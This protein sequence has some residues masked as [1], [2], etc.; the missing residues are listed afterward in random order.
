MKFSK[1]LFFCVLSVLFCTALSAREVNR[2]ELESAGSQ[3]V[4]QFENYT[5]PHSVIDSAAAI[6]GIGIS[7][8]T[9]VSYKPNEAGTFYAS[10][11][12]YYVIHAVDESEK[13]KL[14]A[15]IFII[16]K[17]ATV[18]HIRNLRWIIGSYLQKAYG[19]SESDASTI[20]TFITVYN[21]VYRGKLDVFK[22]KY[23]DVV[24]KNLSADK[25]G[26]STKYSEWPGAT[27]IVIPLND[28]DGGL[29]TI[30]TSVISDKKVVE[31]MQEEDDKGIDERKN[32]VDIKE[33]E[34]EEANENAQ[35]AQKKATEEKAKAKEEQKKADEAKAEAAKDPDN[36][37]KQQA[38][39]EAQKKADEQKQ[40]AEESSE[41][42]SEKQAFADKKQTEAQSERKEIAKDQEKVAEAEMAEA[43]ATD[44][45]IGLKVTDS[46][47]GLS[48]MVKVDGATGKTLRESPV[49]VIRGRTI[50]S[51]TSED[52]ESNEAGSNSL[53][54][55]ICGENTG[56]GAIKLCVLD[57]NK[58]EIQKESN[59]AVAENS[60]L[61]RSGSDILCVI[62]SDGK[63]YLAKYDANLKLIFTSKECVSADTPITVTNKGIVVTAE[64][65]K[66]LLLSKEDFSLVE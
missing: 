34:A 52:D 53:F 65:G 31:S 56:N 30:E 18:D 2:S 5:G 58:M 42:A 17:E 64:N 50:L 19:Y 27:Q 57:G 48:G 1:S 11:K 32:M 23:K 47:K 21:A 4:I 44:A 39:E 63:Y 51:A 25:C 55:A 13:G 38:A 37:E 36:K 33:R 28:I 7:L 40:K 22:G 54:L 24:T 12:K 20:A 6:K 14:D 45:V 43:A 9:D 29:S 59:E 41:E 49:T 60:V 61:V 16:S 3:D 62:T 26:I 15:D 35:K 46:S 10:G 66:V 8:G